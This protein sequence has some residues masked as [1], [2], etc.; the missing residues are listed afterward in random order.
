M[1]RCAKILNIH[2][3]T[4]SRK[5]NFLAAQARLAHQRYLNALDKL[6][7]LIFDEMESFEHSKLKPLSI[8]IF[9]T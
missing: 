4:V 6:D 3:T 2:R 7:H 9:V 5:M 8:P 1:R